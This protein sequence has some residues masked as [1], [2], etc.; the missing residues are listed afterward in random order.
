[1]KRVTWLFH[2]LVLAAMVL[3]A[4]APAQ[5]AA[6]PTAAPSGEITL[7]LVLSTLNN[8]FFVTLRDG[9]QKPPMPRASNSSSWTPRTTPPR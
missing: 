9:A 3:A 5:P 7:G 6:T 1:M 4:C 2:L 8:P